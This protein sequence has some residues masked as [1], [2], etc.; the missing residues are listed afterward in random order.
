MWCKQ[1][2]AGTVKELRRYLAGEQIVDYRLN[3]VA[4]EKAMVGNRLVELSGL[5]VEVGCAI[6][7][8]ARKLGKPRWL[9]ASIK[10]W[11]VV[12]ETSKRLGVGL[13]I[14]RPKQIIN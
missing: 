6:I 1:D 11:G 8:C 7:C 3:T 5:T 2:I 12:L 14:K 4:R 9:L 13:L 10:S